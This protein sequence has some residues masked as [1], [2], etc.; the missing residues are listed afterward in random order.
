M[1]PEVQM[2]KK[3]VRVAD[4]KETVKKKDLQ[5]YFLLRETHKRTDKGGRRHQIDYTIAW[6]V[7]TQIHANLLSSKKPPEM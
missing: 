4:K 7:N 6:V 5:K 3:N 1:K 2:C